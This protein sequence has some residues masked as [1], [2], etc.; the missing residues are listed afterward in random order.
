[1]RSQAC[2]ALL[3]GWQSAVL[4][5]EIPN[6]APNARYESGEVHESIMA[7]KHVREPP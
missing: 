3:A 4:A 1:M 2:V 7:L 5:K 6:P